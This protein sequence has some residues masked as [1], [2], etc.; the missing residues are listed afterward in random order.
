MD[1]PRP[2]SDVS[3]A[4]GYPMP[5]WGARCSVCNLNWP[6]IDPRLFGLPFDHEFDPYAI[7][8]GTAKL[9]CPLCKSEIG[10]FSNTASMEVEEAW[11]LVNH[12]RFRAYY[13]RTRGVDP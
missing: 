1:P 13:R 10:I 5:D 4:Q 2:P 8:S 12:E 11:S 7:R 9:R 6:V 3:G